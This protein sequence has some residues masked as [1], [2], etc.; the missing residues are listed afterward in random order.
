M[1]RS[2]PGWSTRREI[3]GHHALLVGHQTCHDVEQCCLA[4]TAGADQAN[5][6]AFGNI[7]G[8]P[9]QH[10]TAA[11]AGS[12]IFDHDFG[13]HVAPETV[14]SLGFAGVSATPPRR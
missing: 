11:I 1:T 8:D 5:N 7:E 10:V 6:L 4:A 12:E 14:L 13:C 2:G 9:F 3:H